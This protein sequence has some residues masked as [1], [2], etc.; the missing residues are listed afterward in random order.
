MLSA[1]LFLSPPCFCALFSVR[2]LLLLSARRFR[3]RPAYRGFTVAPAIR[4]ARSTGRS[5]DR[6]AHHFMEEPTPRPNTSPD[7][8]R[9][10]V[11]RRS[12]GQT[13]LGTKKR[14]G[15]RRGGGLEGDGQ[16]RP[17][18]AA[19]LS[20]GPGRSAPVHS[21]CGEA[22]LAG[23]VCALRPCS[24]VPSG[25]CGRERP[26]RSG[27]LPIGVGPSSLLP[28]LSLSPSFLCHSLSFS[29]TPPPPC[30]TGVK[31]MLS[32]PPP[33]VFL[34]SFGLLPFVYGCGSSR[35]RAPKQLAVQ[36][37]LSHGFGV[38]NGPHRP[39]E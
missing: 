6:V 3:L 29:G 27:S 18:R 34:D 19:V 28:S 12:K 20:G 24:S 31:H 11:R 21:P 23:G 25:C 10:T 7:P 14:E 8:R 1:P 22:T 15:G 33:F 35:L 36:A 16:V 9:L 5:R 17:D 39:A 38:A 37:V 26:P 4:S 32:P 2:L 30:T 13:G